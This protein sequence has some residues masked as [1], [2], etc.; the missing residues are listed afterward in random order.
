MLGAASIGQSNGMDGSQGLS[1]NI[2]QDASLHEV[3]TERGRQEE[4]STQLI[5]VNGQASD[6]ILLSNLSQHPK[7]EDVGMKSTWWRH[8]ME[9][10]SALLAICAGNS[11]VLSE[12]LAQKPVTRSF[13]VFFDPRLNKRLSKQ[14]WGRWFGT[15]SHPLWRHGNDES[16]SKERGCGND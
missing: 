15:L 14:W 3:L 1:Q 10:F 13:G 7:R 9:T 6:S 12:F 8:Q 11:P 2:K 4:K 16:E 5:T